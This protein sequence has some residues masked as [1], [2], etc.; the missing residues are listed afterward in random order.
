VQALMDEPGLFPSD[1]FTDIVMRCPGDAACPPQPAEVVTIEAEALHP[2]IGAPNTFYVMVAVFATPAQAEDAANDLAE[3]AQR[4]DGAFDHPASDEDGQLGY[5]EVGT[6]S[7]RIVVAQRWD[8]FDLRTEY[9][10]VDGGGRESELMSSALVLRSA[11]NVL[12]YVR[13]SGP[14]T[15]FGEGVDPGGEYVNELLSGLDQL[16]PAGCS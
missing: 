1:Y 10:S 13:L 14:T 15:T 16:T 9:R 5:S 2:M 11:C 7:T 8:G 3:D 6:G 12:L 4:Y